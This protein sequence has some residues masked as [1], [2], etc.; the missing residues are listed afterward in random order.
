MKRSVGI[1]ISSFVII[2][3]SKDHL[4]LINQ[5]IKN[6]YYLKLYKKPLEELKQ[7]INLLNHQ[8]GKHTHTHEHKNI[9]RKLEN[10][11]LH[12]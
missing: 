11:V 8:K 7:T 1:L 5:E 12:S 3:V 2:R 4:K 6:S 9:H 10:K